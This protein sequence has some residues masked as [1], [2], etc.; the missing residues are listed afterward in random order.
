MYHCLH[1]FIWNTVSYID[2]IQ[3]N[4]QMPENYLYIFLVFICFSKNVWIVCADISNKRSLLN[5]SWQFIQGVS[6]GIVN[7]LGGGSMDYS[8]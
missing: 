5:I 8:E 7:I 3:I 2:A 1:N 6:G 4:A